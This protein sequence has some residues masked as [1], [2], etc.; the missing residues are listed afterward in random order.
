MVFV[1][2]DFWHGRR[3]RERGIDSL[4]AQFKARRRFWT[5]KILRNVQ[6]DQLVNQQLLAGGWTVVRLWESDIKRDLDRAIRRVENAIRS[7]HAR[8]RAR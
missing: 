3:F 1:D 8:R 4:K 7:A 2:G 5:A 6:R